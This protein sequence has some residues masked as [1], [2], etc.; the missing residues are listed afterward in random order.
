MALVT[1]PLL[2]QCAA[3]LIF[4][5][6]L[7]LL[8]TGLFSA[9]LEPL[10]ATTL[11]WSIQHFPMATTNDGQSDAASSGFA[12]P[13]AVIGPSRLRPQRTPAASGGLAPENF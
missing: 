11:A 13:A 10:A 7:L 6:L 8:P 3:L 9:D 4:V 12:W 2:L 5:S 1:R